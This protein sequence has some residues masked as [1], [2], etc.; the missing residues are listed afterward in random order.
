M[1]DFVERAREPKLST[2]F[3][4]ILKDIFDRN[5]VNLGEAF[6]SEVAESLSAAVQTKIQAPF[7]SPIK[8]W[9]RITYLRIEPRTLTAC[10]DVRVHVSGLSLQSEKSENAILAE[11][12]ALALPGKMSPFR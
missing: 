1:L 10:H 5:N 12:T 8:K 9:D 6:P 2:V 3:T 7:K 4:G 11:S